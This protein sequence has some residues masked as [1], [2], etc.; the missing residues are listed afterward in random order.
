[1]YNSKKFPNVVCT[2][3]HLEVK[4]SSTRSHIY[5]LVFH[6]AGIPTTCRINSQTIQNRYRNSRRNGGFYNS[7]AIVIHIQNKTTRTFTLC[8]SFFFICT[9]AYGHLRSNTKRLFCKRKTLIGFVFC[10]CRSEER[11]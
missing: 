3:W 9:Y 2:H 1:M 4:H 6:Y 11:R 5:P 8:F 10:A 7:H